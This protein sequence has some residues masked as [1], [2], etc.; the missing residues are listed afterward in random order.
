MPLI[1]L[2]N[3]LAVCIIFSTFGCGESNSEKNEDSN[4]EVPAINVSMSHETIK[5]GE[6]LVCSA[7]GVD[8]EDGDISESVVYAWSNGEQDLELSET[9]YTVQSSDDP[10]DTIT[11]TATVT[12]SSG[13][14]ASSSAETVVEN[15][16]VVFNAEA[17]LDVSGVAVSEVYV[18]QTLKCD[19]R[20]SDADGDAPTVSIQWLLDD[21]MVSGET[22]ST[23]TVDGGDV[24]IGQ[25]F[26]CKVTLSD[27][28]PNSDGYQI[29]SVSSKAQVIAGLPY[30]QYNFLGEAGYYRAGKVVSSAG[31][32]D[33]DGKDDLMVMASGRVYILLAA[34]LSGYRS[35]N[36]ILSDAD[37]IIEKTSV[38]GGPQTGDAH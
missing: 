8:E 7:S 17:H 31:D 9:E 27:T 24:S 38:T 30:N 13:A 29:E 21:T 18:G 3:I 20:S 28:S 19:Y 14:S 6:Q 25:S 32:I 37:Y 36:I 16:N 33:G 12:D 22:E 2:Q 5:V 35:Q 1:R 4:N 11:C 34:S 23:L 15:T 10:G 26:S